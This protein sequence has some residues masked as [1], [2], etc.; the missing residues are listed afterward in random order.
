[1]RTAS[2][3]NPDD[4]DIVS[5]WGAIKR[6]LPR[7]L[8]FTIGA[9]V[10]TFAALSTMA[11]RFTSEAQLAIV[12]KTTNPFPDGRDKPG[13]SDSVTP[14]M[15]KEAINTQVR[16][17]LSTD[18]LLKVAKKMDLASLPEF[19]PRV[20]DLDLYAKAMRIIGL[21]KIR[22]GETVDD[23]VLAG[24]GRQLEISSPK[25]SRAINIRFS[26]ADPALAASFANGLAEDY[27]TTLVTSTVDETSDVVRALEPKVDQ[28][29]RELIDAEAEVERTRVQIDR[30]IGGQTKTPLID[31]R[32]SELTAELSRADVQKSDAESKWR[33]AREMMQSGTTASL[34]EVQKSPLIQNLEQQRVRL[35]RNISELSASLLPGH[36]RMQQLNADLSGLKRQIT[37]EIQK[38]TVSLEKESRVATLRFD[39]IQKQI[40]DLKGRVISTS[41]DDAKLRSIEAN[42]KSKRAE[43]ERLQ[44]QLEDNKTVIVTKTVPIEARLVTQARPSSVA[45]FP[46]KVPFSTLAMAG[47][48]LLGL[49]WMVTRELLTGAR[50]TPGSTGGNGQRRSIN[51]ADTGAEPSLG[52]ALA[53]RASAGAA[54][55]SALATS[56]AAAAASRSSAVVTT[57]NTPGNTT[58]NADGHD[59]SVAVDR[60]T[61]LTSIDKVASRILA[62]SAAQAGFRSM[63]APESRAL[64]ASAEAI[65]LVKAIAKSGKQVLLVDW[66]LDGTGYSAALGV[67]NKPGL[68]DLLQGDVSFEDVIARVP[69]SEA[70]FIA[71]GDELADPSMADDADRI[72]LVLDALD[73]AY[74][75]I[76]I[77][78]AHEEVRAL[79][80]TIEGRFDAGITVADPRRRQALIEDA[81]GSFLGFE[82]TDLEVIQYDRMTSASTTS[83]NTSSGAPSASGKWTI[84]GRSINGPAADAR[85]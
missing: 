79:F 16:A 76:V 77:A 13:S 62:A 57:G 71:S 28:L 74:D 5:L 7:L 20:G 1:M 37:A 17:L 3:A 75:H 21:A 36:P 30:T 85:P 84:G 73:E 6:G 60:V 15:D 81:P 43:L 68:T 53:T 50:A 10:L 83:V 55:A 45:T 8:M 33:A 24:I 31:Q 35:E 47:T 72:N 39:S 26:S 22:D 70:H 18:L 12:A 46:K 78:G 38:L 42:A 23:T 25:E 9:G 65:E 44:K 34:P 80:Q 41:G 32:L 48:F 69:G 82:V 58:G 14:R 59:V 51:S 52:R 29:R 61:R 27:R 66:S 64:D 4:I 49:A 2:G 56:G 11:P 40:T 63:L 19:N 54:V 67:P